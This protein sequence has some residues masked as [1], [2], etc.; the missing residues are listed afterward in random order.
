MKI[1]GIG[2]QKAQMA[3]GVS[4]AGQSESNAGT[5]LS[6]RQ[7][8]HAALANFAGRAATNSSSSQL[9]LSTFDVAPI[10]T[11]TRDLFER[12]R[13]QRPA[14]PA[15]QATQLSAQ[16]LPADSG[17]SQDRDLSDRN[18]AATDAGPEQQ[19]QIATEA[20]V[21]ATDDAVEV[22]AAASAPV[23]ATA[24]AA[25]PAAV[26]K[27][28][29]EAPPEVMEGETPLA[30]NLEQANS[31]APQTN[32]KKS[33][34]SADNAAKQ[35]KNQPQTALE[36]TTESTAQP[37]PQVNGSPVV[38]VTK[39]NASEDAESRG[40]LAAGQQAKTADSSLTA[41]LAAMISQ[42]VSTAGSASGATSDG[43]R[44][45]VSRITSPSA[46]GRNEVGG[47]S[48][49]NI[50]ID[51]GLRGEFSKNA[52]QVTKPSRIQPSKL[53]ERIEATLKEAAR[54]RDGKTISL[55]LDPPDLGAVKVDVTIRD[56]GLHARVTA[57]NAQVA[58][59]IREKAYELQSMLRKLG[60]AVEKV[61]ISVHEGMSSPQGE[62]SQGFAD[63][64]NSRSQ[65]QEK[66]R[67][68]KDFSVGSSFA[69]PEQVAT[70]AVGAHGSAKQE[71]PSGWVA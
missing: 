47:Q 58:S 10:P 7:E 11:Q 50:R 20:E 39:P 27:A 6:L 52:E 38:Q 18:Q 12:P 60:L 68:F 53:L 37:L 48:A 32:G 44:D 67:E 23:V 49:P 64:G 55:R 43:A 42:R 9:A 24:Q 19:E 69:S 70:P 31:S 13:E 63:T 25:A 16:E 1:K 21:S 41:A 54:S 66:P 45:A 62:F 26:A 17:A 35:G 5:D 34:Y 22:P 15:D 29:A 36:A 4:Q 14:L 8:F 56:G 28:G 46:S 57:D 40:L 61:T 30:S 59:V 33:D 2:A 3:Q 65:N 51:Q 71:L